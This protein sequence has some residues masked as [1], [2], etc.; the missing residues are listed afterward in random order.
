MPSQ[1]VEAATRDEAIA[2]AREQFGPTARV[3]GVRRIRSGGMF[4]FFTNERF[5]AEVEVPKADPVKGPDTGS[6]LKTGAREPRPAASMDDRMQ[7]LAELLGS[8]SP[9]PQPVGLY[10]RAGA[11]PAAAPSA[12]APSAAARPV[13]RAAAP[14]ST[15]AT[16]PSSVRTAS[17]ARAATPARA[18][19]PVP[20]TREPAAAPRRADAKPF[21][22]TKH[23]LMLSPEDLAPEPVEPAQRA[24]E[25]A[26]PSPFAAALTR[27]VASNPVQV[28]AEAAAEAAA[29]EAEAREVAAADAAAARV[30]AVESAAAE[31]A[32]AAAARVDAAA[33]EAARLRAEAAAAEAARLQAV[34]A[35]AEA[36]RRDA[37]AAAAE[38]A[39]LEAEAA[40]AEAARLEAERLEAERLEAQRLEAQRLEAERLEAARIEAARIEAQRL[41]AQRLEA[42][43]LEAQRLEAQRLE[44]ERLE[45]ERLEAE[46]LE[47]ERLE[48]ER[49]EAARIEAA[50]VEAERLEAE[51]LEAERLEAVRIEVA[52]QEAARVEAAR[53][54]A[55]RIEAARI[56]AARVEAARRQAAADAEAAR[57]E[58]VR[59]EAARIVAERLGTERRER[60]AVALAGSPLSMV[61][62]VRSADEALAALLEEVLAANGSGRG[63]HRLPEAGAPLAV[64]AAPVTAEQEL[65]QPSAYDTRGAE[66][67][68]YD[69]GAH[70]PDAWSGPGWASDARVAQRAAQVAAAQALVVDAVV[71]A[72]T[73]AEEVRVT[74]PRPIEVPVAVPVEEQRFAVPVSLSAPLARTASD[75]AP[76]PMDATLV[77]PRLS[78]TGGQPPQSQR[79]AVPPARRG[80]PPVPASRPAGTGRTPIATRPVPVPVPI[81]SRRPA[82]ELP[83]GPETSTRLATVTRLVP[84]VSASTAL[85]P[86]GMDV[87][88]ELVVRL[89]TLGLPAS[90]LGPDFT[91]DAALRGV[92][93]A[94]TR[95]LAERLPAAPHLPTQPGDVL[96]VVGPGAETFAAARS[97]ALSLRLE[98]ED[99]QWAASG[100]LAGLAPEGSRITSL[101][102]AAERQQASAAR[103]TVTIIAVD[104]PLRTSG[105]PWLEH[106]LTIWSP[107]AV[108]GVLDSTRKPE[109]LVPW[110]DGLPRLDAVVVQDTDSTADPAAVLDH[111]SVPVAL[112]DGAR[113]TAH[114]WA[115]LLCERLEE[116]EG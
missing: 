4:G 84:A 70:R 43:R 69:T 83:A 16:A 99:V 106:M 96:M 76:L 87:A 55:A 28:A 29:A 112:V 63:R 5:I 40:A 37:E 51:R 95:T 85:A 46:R 81:G 86:Y 12:A 22:P 66:S 89:L 19:S 111:V 80:R 52:R 109:D 92:Y 27:M 2:A 3:V 47:A 41:E 7:E 64:T 8:A 57:V 91:D 35:A 38:A 53:V 104:A 45:A 58:A 82:A 75:P 59:Q 23:T 56:E 97:L 42:Q 98:P 34:A 101:E 60:E 33:A 107:T 26:G 14:A 77:L 116:L 17:P 114:R 21:T 39:R 67:S 54:E 94:L 90:L 72:E 73:A 20:T 18:A 110:L 24:A 30:A 103:G 13:R 93:A 68:A 74:E 44:A 78:I 79:P 113:A 36:A 1:S 31:A 71:V 88:E 62:S 15:G 9:E 10:G 115:S 48:A 102:T 49:L 105:G 25:P 6:L 32:R 11:Q 100:A 50:R 65:P 61:E 108:W